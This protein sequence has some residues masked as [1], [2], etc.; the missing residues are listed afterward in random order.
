M[1][2]R[3]EFDDDDVR[4]IHAAV[5][6]KAESGLVKAR[7]RRNLATTK[8]PVEREKFWDVL[9]GCLLTS[10]QRSGPDSPVS[11]FLK[12][13]NF[14][15][16]LTVC[17]S[18]C[19]LGA[20]ALNHLQGFGGIRFGKKISKQ[21][22]E[23]LAY[24]TGDAWDGCVAELERLRAEQTLEAERRAA[25]HFDWQFA[26]VGPKQSRNLLQILGLTRHEIPVDSRIVKW[27]KRFGFPVPL[28]AFALA[29]ADYYEFVEDG[30][31]LLCRHADVLPC[32][33]DASIFAS[34]DR[35][36]WTEEESIW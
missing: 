23:N 26:G 17:E 32:V 6:L 10:V 30:I 12:P 35:R 2:F 29:D 4:K 8:P 13:K 22:C 5:A 11:N 14:K 7:I 3:W 36:E 1:R 27:L 24:M 20:T 16:T 21:L 15:L 19:D 34:Y 9:V 25:R 31:Q 33:L 18:D 28:S